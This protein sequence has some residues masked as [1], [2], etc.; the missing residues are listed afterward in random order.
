MKQ[1]IELNAYYVPSFM[2][3][4]IN[5][6]IHRRETKNYIKMKRSVVA[7]DGGGE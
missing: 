6:H 4:L 3:I 7:R 1:K 5:T 2:I